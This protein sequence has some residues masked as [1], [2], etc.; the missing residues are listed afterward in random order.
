MTLTSLRKWFVREKLPRTQH[1]LGFSRR[2]IPQF[3]PLEDRTAPAVITPFTLRFQA[4]TTGDIVFVS[5]TILRAPTPAGNAGTGDNNSFNMQF[6]DVDNDPATFNSSQATLALP[7]GAEVLF[8]GLYWG[9]ESSSPLRTQVLFDT[10]AAGGPRTVGGG[11]RGGSS[12]PGENLAPGQQDYHVFADVTP[13]VQA[14][15]NGVYTVANI[16]ATTGTDQ[17]GGWALVIVYQDADAPAKNLSVFDGFAF[18]SPTG[19]PADQTVPIT[20]SGFQTPPTGPV[21]ANI[22]FITYEGDR[23]RTGDGAT[24]QSGGG[25]S[26]ALMDSQ[27]P[28]NNFFNSTISNQGSLVT[29][30]N[31]N[32][33]N[34]LGFDA[35]ILQVPNVNNTIIANGATSAT[36]TLT[37]TLA[38]AGDIF[39]PGVVTT[40]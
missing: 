30:K 19:T 26:L 36:V 35:D 13:L 33:T 38:G 10:P 4:N 7:A 21:N 3:E 2:Y 12:I 14:A 6:V 37:A 22:G 39:Y 18:V 29:T 34:Q 1:K 8:A 31:P 25:P 28:A 16:Q 15:G 20:V 23:G 17:H 11:L 32:F 5:N 40:A 24:L 27:N 9:A